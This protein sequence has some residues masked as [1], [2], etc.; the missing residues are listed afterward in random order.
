MLGSYFWSLM[1]GGG[2]NP[3]VQSVGTIMVVGK[4]DQLQKECHH[5]MSK[6]PFSIML[7]W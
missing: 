5:K 3:N 7:G 1:V 6:T 2:S 4:L